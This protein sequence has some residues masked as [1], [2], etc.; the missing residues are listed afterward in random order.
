MCLKYT[1]NKKPTIEKKSAKEII[2]TYEN[3]FELNSGAT[4]T[5]TIP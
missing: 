5:I 1:I 3:G 2:L 4:K